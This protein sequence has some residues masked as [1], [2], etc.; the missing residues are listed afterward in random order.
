[1][2]GLEKR[3]IDTRVQSFYSSN[4]RRHAMQTQLRPP[5]QTHHFITCSIEKVAPNCTP[6]SPPHTPC[7]APY[8]V[9][10]GLQQRPHARELGDHAP[11][12]RSIRQHVQPPPIVPR[13]ADGRI[14]EHRK[15]EVCARGVKERGGA[16]SEIEKEGGASGGSKAEG[17]RTCWRRTPSTGRRGFGAEGFEKDWVVTGGR[18]LYPR[19]GGD[20]NLVHTGPSTPL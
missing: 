3:S 7:P 13:V 9:H 4:V 19:K 18:A 2:R 1:M 17:G 14:Q 12:P 10:E 6:P 20:G 8:L 11:Q 15:P 5:L 16:R